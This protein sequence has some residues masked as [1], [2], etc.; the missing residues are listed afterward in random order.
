MVDAFELMRLFLASNLF[1]WIFTSS[2]SSGSLSESVALSKTCP[3]EEEGLRGKMGLSLLSESFP[4]VMAR[5]FLED[6]LILK[7]GELL[8]FAGDGFSRSSSS[9]SLPDSLS[10]EEVVSLAD[11]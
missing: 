8:F 2:G 11:K 7:S 10:D 6:L 4:F 9:S 1:W 5:V 3:D